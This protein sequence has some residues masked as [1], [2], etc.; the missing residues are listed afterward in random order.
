MTFDRDAHKREW[1]RKRQ[2][3]TIELLRRWK[4]SKGCSHCGYNNPIALVLDH[5]D[6]ATKDK[7]RKSGRAINPLWCKERIK[8]E[9]ALCQVLC[10][11]CHT[12]RTWEEEHFLPPSKKS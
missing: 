7:N 11:N 5:I 2:S 4:R 9:L 1:N 6:P 8:K 3:Y 10:A 12:I